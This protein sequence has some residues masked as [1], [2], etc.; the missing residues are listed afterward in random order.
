MTKQTAVAAGPAYS[1]PMFTM[2]QTMTDAL[3]TFVNNAIT[4]YNN[5]TCAG[6]SAS[7]AGLGGD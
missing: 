2:S 6:A 7:D 3:N 5:K 1:H 4:A